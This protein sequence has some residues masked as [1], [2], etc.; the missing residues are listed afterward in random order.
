MVVTAS[1]PTRPW[2]AVATTSSEMNAATKFR[3]AAY[4][5]AKRG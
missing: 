5:T 1:D 3:I 2:P 4:V